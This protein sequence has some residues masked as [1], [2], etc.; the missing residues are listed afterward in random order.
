MKLY[1]S[2]TEVRVVV[3]VIPVAFLLV[4]VPLPVSVVGTCTVVDRLPL[5]IVTVYL[6]PVTVLFME[7][8]KPVTVFLLPSS[9]VPVTVKFAAL[10]SLILLTVGP[11]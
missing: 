7:M 6:P 1:P 9:Y 10:I 8:P 5:V 4:P 2:S 11:L 3:A